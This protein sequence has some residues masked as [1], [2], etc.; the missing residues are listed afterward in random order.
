[1]IEMK[2][3]GQ[4]GVEQHHPRAQLAF[5]ALPNLHICIMISFFFKK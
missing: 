3:Q 2:R 4:G 1:M 5:K